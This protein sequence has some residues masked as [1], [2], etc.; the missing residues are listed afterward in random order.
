VTKI[1]EVTKIGEAQSKGGNP[2]E[3]ARGLP[4]VMPE[5]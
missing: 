4:E 2:R 5:P 3:E 1:S